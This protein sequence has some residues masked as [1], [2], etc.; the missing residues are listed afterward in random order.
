M[1][2][3]DKSNRPWE[4]GWGQ[5]QSLNDCV[6]S[7]PYRFSRF[8][9]GGTPFHL[10]EL[11]GTSG[12]PELMP[13]QRWLR[14]PVLI[15]EYDWLWITRDGQ[16]TSLTQDVYREVLGGGAT[17]AQ[18]RLFYARAMAALTEYWRCHRQAAAVMEF[19][20][21]AIPARAPSRGPKAAPRATIS[22]TWRPWKWNLPTPNTSAR[23]SIPSP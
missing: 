13:S 9:A 4:N 23:P 3:I 14:V 20:R 6:E 17:A 11:E 18:R 2:R 5:P 10:C 21:W 19:C 12:E 7:H 16:P 15:N 8:W 1:R 22:S